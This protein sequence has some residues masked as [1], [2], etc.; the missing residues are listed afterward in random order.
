MTT[1]HW[2]YVI[3][4]LVVVA[5]MIFRRNVVIPC[6]IFTFVIGLYF[7]GSA[8]SAVQVVFNAS[9]VAAKE[10]FGI[11]LIIGLMVA[12]L[13][14]LQ[15]TGADE[16]FVKPLNKM[17]T[18]PLVSYIVIII[19][20]VVISLFFWPTPAAPL[21]GAL[22]I[23]AAIKVGLPPMMA[24]VALA[25]A[26]QGMTLAGDTLIQAAPGIT[27][28]AAGVPVELVTSKALILT[29]ITGIIAIVLAWIMNKKEID[30][31]DAKAH[32]AQAAATAETG[33]ATIAETTAKDSSKGK[34]MVW[35]MA[36]AFAGVI[37]SMFAFDIKGGDSSA[38]LG[39]AAIL[40]VCFAAML[41]DGIKGLDTVA[42]F[43]ADGLVFAFKVMGPIIPIAGFFFLGS[44]DFA[45]AILGEG[46]PGYLFDIGKIIGEAI[47][48]T[49][50][51][52]GFGLLILGAITG[53]DG[54]GFS[55]LPVVGTLAGAMAGGNANVA[56]TLGSIGQMGAIWF[57]GGALVAWSSLVAVAGICGVSVLDL[58]RKNLIPVLV[59]LFVS[60]CFAVFFLM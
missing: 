20:T 59:G 29:L 54:S 36:L 57:G 60:T 52:A 11:F 42:D 45:P 41:T 53:L 10:L 15:A 22:L 27:A 18:G 40:I 2:L 8:V 47:P 6:I 30:A 33:A 9:L 12:L 49:G 39:G 46:A 48:P 35:V 44:A 1:A 24:A 43:I 14:T 3:G 5:T 34:T 38:L 26:G 50:F 17:M 37:F 28:G 16:L 25:L 19:A 58:V 55:G 51:A 32:E 4:V 13:K 7:A 23:P 31:F 56:A 21:L